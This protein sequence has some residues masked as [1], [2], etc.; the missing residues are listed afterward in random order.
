MGTVLCIVRCLASLQVST[1]STPAAA[2]CLAVTITTV[3]R[4]YQMPLAPEN[5][6]LNPSGDQLKGCIRWPGLG[7]GG[8]KGGR[9]ADGVDRLRRCTGE[10][11]AS[12][13]VTDRRWEIAEE[14]RKWGWALTLWREQL[15]C[16]TYWAKLGLRGA[17]AEI[18]NLIF[19][20]DFGDAGDAVDASN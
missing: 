13:L 5:A 9:Q 2:T 16:A 20:V 11:K 1:C 14:N 19:H 6:A 4:R 8:R 3:F 7:W 12:G 18:T 15:C 10:G 17:E